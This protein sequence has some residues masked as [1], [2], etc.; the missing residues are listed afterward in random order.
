[1]ASAVRPSADDWPFADPRSIL[2]RY[3]IR[4]RKSLGQHFLVDR[5]ALERILAAAALGDE[6]V[7]L[8]IG[9]GVGV[10]TRAL[11]AQAAQVV[12]V[13]IDARLCDVLTDELGSCPN[14]RVTQA[15]ILTLDPATACGLAPTPIG[16]RRGFKVVGNLPYYITS[17]VLRHLLSATVRPEAAIL[18]VQSEVGE[19]LLATPPRMSLLAVSVQLHAQPSL[20]ARIPA[21]AF[22]PPP[23]VDSHVL[24][25][26]V[27][28]AP[29]VEMPAGGESAFFRIVKAG[30]GQRR[31]Q[32]R[33]SLAAGLALPTEEVASALAHA[34]ID[35][36]RRPETLTLEEWSRLALLLSPGS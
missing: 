3:A 23:Q 31:K 6:D 2:R 19:R 29:A 12:A 15:D 21:R 16:K 20:V 34:G 27:R 11:A 28:E 24:H 8:E 9:A 35:A 18:T 4:P 36:R 22:Y 10:L 30:F 1:M 25:L 14:V 17:A 26:A 32:L 33:N 13:E 5:G 7:V